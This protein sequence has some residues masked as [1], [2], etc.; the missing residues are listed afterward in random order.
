MLTRNHNPHILIRLVF[1]AILL[2]LTIGVPMRVKARVHPA[3]ADRNR[4]LDVQ[5]AAHGRDAMENVPKTALR[6]N[7]PGRVH[8]GAFIG[9]EPLRATEAVT[10]FLPTAFRDYCPNSFSDDFS[11]VASGWPIE[12]TAEDSVGYENGM[13]RMR[14]K[15]VYIW[16]GVTPGVT[17]GDS[18]RVQVDVKNDGPYGPYGILFGRSQSGW[19]E[20]YALFVHLD[21]FFQIWRYKS[22]LADPWILLKSGN[23]GQGNGLL[24][25]ER[26]GASIRA[27]INGNLLADITDDTYRGPRKVGLIISSF[28]KPYDPSTNALFDNFFVCGTV[29]AA[30]ITEFGLSPVPLHSAH[31]SR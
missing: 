26:N 25:V 27:F 4:S 12:D 17:V 10:T 31:D 30:G 20:F 1:A 14:I 5:P 16:S 7:T 15:N 24:K 13:Y 11:N 22:G 6:S 8:V 23:S 2:V 18:Y 28:E 29:S 3:Q 21:G 9:G 19:S